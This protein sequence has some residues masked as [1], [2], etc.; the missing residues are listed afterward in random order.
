M[1]DWFRYQFKL[2]INEIEMKTKEHEGFKK[3]WLK[4]YFALN[5]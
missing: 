2:S 5:E 3:I 1:K 4:P